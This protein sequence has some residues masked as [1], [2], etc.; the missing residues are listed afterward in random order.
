MK[1]SK[2]SSN[3]TKRLIA[4]T[5]AAGLGA[6]AFTQQADAALVFNSGSVRY[7]GDEG[8]TFSPVNLGDT[9]SALGSYEIDYNGDSTYDVSVVLDRTPANQQRL[10][11]LNVTGSPTTILS[12]SSGGYYIGAMSEGASTAGRDASSGVGVAVRDDY[13]HNGF[14]NHP[15]FF[16]FE[17]DLGGGNSEFGWVQLDVTDAAGTDGIS[18]VIDKYAYESVDNQAA[19]TTSVIPEPSTYAL[20][21]GCLALG[22]AGLRAR[23]RKTAS[24]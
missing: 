2:L 19:I 16:G 18:F 12:T 15:A 8:A 17:T 3:S 9:L 11:I 13:L 24:A 22:A 4:Y 6:F 5:S 20:G 1:N 21:L 14:V 10:R 7:T 23:R